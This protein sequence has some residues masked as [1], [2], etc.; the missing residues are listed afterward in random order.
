[1]KKNLTETL[2]L[3]CNEIGYLEGDIVEL[4]VGKGTNA[5]IFSEWI[6]RNRSNKRYYGIDTFCG[7]GEE[8]YEE[9]PNVEGLKDNDGRWDWKRDLL[10]EELQRDKLDKYCNI[11]SG[12]IKEKTKSLNTINKKISMIYID[13]NAYLPS[14]VGLNNLKSKLDKNAL[15]II[16]SGGDSSETNCG[17]YKALKE[18][19]D[20]K[21]LEIYKEPS[22]NFAGAWIIYK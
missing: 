1:M 10:I 13:C 8:D 2:W 14:I 20:N 17:E 15:I 5:I 3:F 18:F 16:D 21:K 12:D 11:I 19:A 22:R 9:D 6:K 7:Y 4:G